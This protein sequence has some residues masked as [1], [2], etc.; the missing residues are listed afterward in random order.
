MV[1]QTRHA[2]ARRQGNERRTRRVKRSRQ[3]DVINR[4]KKEKEHKKMD[5]RR[6]LSE[7][8]ERVDNGA[9]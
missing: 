6:W 9:P 2:E 4:R 5:D 8:R 1:E 3:S 7:K